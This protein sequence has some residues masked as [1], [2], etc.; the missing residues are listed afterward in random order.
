MIHLLLCRSKTHPSPPISS[1][2][3][4]EMA[5]HPSSSS[6]NKKSQT[7]LQSKYKKKKISAALREQVWIHTAGRVFERKCSVSWC[8]NMIDVFSFQCG[9]NIPE[10]KG[11]ATTLDNLIPICGRC[12]SSMGSSY[13][14]DEWTKLHRTPRK[15]FGRKWLSLLGFK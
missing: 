4:K 9:H 12:N 2:S 1:E 8:Q 15:W 14:L 3:S 13:T 5:K 7:P 10:S 11:G 6:P